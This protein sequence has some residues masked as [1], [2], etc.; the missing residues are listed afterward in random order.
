MYK[1]VTVKKYYHPPDSLVLNSSLMIR[2][3]E[4]IKENPAITDEA[5]HKLVE[6]ALLWNNK[7]DSLNMD[8]Y[9]SLIS[10]T[11]PA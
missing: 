2:L 6:V 11:P 8:C 3:L 5:I 4:Y 10:S 7:Y 9:S 1:K